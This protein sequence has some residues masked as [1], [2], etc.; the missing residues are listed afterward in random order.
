MANL[1]IVWEDDALRLLMDRDRYTRH[2]IQEE[3]R[4]DPQRDAI[5]LDADE[6]EYLTQVSNKRYTVVWHFDRVRQ[7][8]IVR[9]VVPLTNIDPQ[10]DGLKEYVQRAV[11]R[12]IKR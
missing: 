3:F 9:A 7:Q 10:A 12:E 2:V 11:E 5:E 1:K 8:A 6:G 4:Q